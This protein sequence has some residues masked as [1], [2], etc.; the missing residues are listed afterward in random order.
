[1]IKVEAFRGKTVAVFGLARSGISSA[2]ALMEGGAKVLGW[3]EKPDA[4][5][6]AEKAG[7]PVRS[8][9]EV[10]WRDVAALVLSPGVPLTHPAP[11]PFVIQAREANAEIIGDVELFFRTIRSSPDGAHPKIVCIT[12]TNGKSTTTALIGHLLDRLGFEAETGGNIGKPL[13][14]L[15][16]PSAKKAYVLELSSFQIDL[17]PSV[18]PDVAVLI[19]VTPDHLDRHGT[20]DNYARVKSNIF[21]RQ[22]KGDHAIIG[23][24]DGYSSEICTQLSSRSDVTVSPVSVGKVLGR[25][26]FVVDG[27]LFDASGPTSREV[28]DLKTLT[29]L[30]GSH[31]WQNIAMAYAAVRPLVKDPRDIA[32]VIPTF[33]GLEHRIESV[34]SLGNVRFVNDSK[35]TNADAAARALACFDRIFW[36]AGGKAKDGGIDCLAPYFGKIAKTYLIGAATESFA[37]TLDGAVPFEK[38]VTLDSAMRHAAR[39]ALAAGGSAVVLLSPACASFDQFRDFEHRG[40]EFKRIFKLMAD[41][42]GATGAS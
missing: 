6:A 3:D 20:M 17:T 16:T 39:D 30:P 13:L 8:L 21:A 42:A 24:D 34:G 37:A 25:G 19:N 5:A 4:R 35:A 12:G 2:R 38:S 29:H 33:P 32:R 22:G 14:E 18:H 27:V 9:H 28:M 41:E 10:N 15:D 1:M 31:N 26:V 7:I 23:V 40:N 11:H 36:I